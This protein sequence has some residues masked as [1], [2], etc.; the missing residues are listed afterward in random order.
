MTYTELTENSV[1]LPEDVSVTATERHPKGVKKKKAA[2]ITSRICSYVFLGLLSLVFLFP[3]I[4]MV[5]LS[6]LTDREVQMQVLFSPTGTI[7]FGTYIAVLSAKS[8]YLRYIF[9]TLEVAA[10]TTVGIPLVSSLCAYGFAKMQFKGKEVIFAIVLGTMMIPAVIS[11]VP[12]YTIYA[13]LGWIDTL[14]PMW[15][16]SL[17]GGGATNIFLMRQFMRGIPNDMIKAAQLDGANSFV[18][19]LRLMIPLCLPTMLYVAVQSFMGAWNDFMTPFTYLNYGSKSMTLA[20]GM[21]YD[22]GPASTKLANE[23]MAAGVVMTLPCAVLFF[24]FQKYLIDGV[25]VTGMKD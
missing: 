14:F 1:I 20:L 23:A 13:K 5:C 15:V 4:V 6:L 3:F 19:Y 24:C 25:A 2:K 16:P 21:Y 8:G 17:F 9:N 10:I 7:N 11:I 12:L 22:Y 18:I